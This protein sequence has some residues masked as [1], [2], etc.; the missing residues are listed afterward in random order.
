M[1]VAEIIAIGTELL[2][3]QIQDTN[4]SYIARTLN[5]SGIDIFRAA[6]IGDN[7]TR[8][9]GVIRETLDR[10]DIVITTGGLGPTVDDPT[11]SAV[12]LAF[13]TQNEYQPDLWEEIQERFRGYGRTPSENNKRQAF[14]PGGAVV[15]HN[16]VG[17][18]PAF[19]IEKNGKILF[20]LPGVPSEM[21]TLLHENVIPMILA[22][23]KLESAIVT[24]ILHTIGIGESSVDE[25]VGELESLQ[26]PTVG[27]AAHPGQVDIRITAK[28]RSR[29]EAL[30]L[31][32]PIEEQIKSLLGEYVYGVDG[33]RISEIVDD[34][35]KSGSL[36]PVIFYDSVYQ[37]LAQLIQEHLQ[38]EVSIHEIS[39][40]PNE[41][42]PSSDTQAQLDKFI[43]NLRSLNGVE[44][45]VKIFGELK[46][47]S[48]EKTLRFGGHPSL[49]KQWA[50]NQILGFMRE[51]IN[52]GTGVK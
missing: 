13:D 9:A 43:V 24:R 39:E 17:T 51:M 32:S 42:S 27:L 25:L 5:A 18:A 31:I 23:Y 44:H 15:I 7:E 14:L 37:D 20:S 48:F 40:F 11:R 49:Y 30:A 28:A 3:G 26:N 29:D 16:P 21:K 36:N 41:T 1:P 19:Y 35:L 6:M 38:T 22:K 2:L 34:L 47:N 8:I 50:A 46:N 52:K 4:T 33:I 10:A 45:Q 12:A